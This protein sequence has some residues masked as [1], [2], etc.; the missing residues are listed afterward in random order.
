MEK[1]IL[2]FANHSL[3]F[4]AVLCHAGNHYEYKGKR[5]IH[6]LESRKLPR[7]SSLSPWKC[8]VLWILMVFL[9]IEQGYT[10][11]IRKKQFGKNLKGT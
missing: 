3:C 4:Y 2:D 8:G 9:S 7:P 6:Q 10:E 1:V 5:Q 11:Q